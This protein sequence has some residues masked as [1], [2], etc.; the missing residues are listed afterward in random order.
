MIKY[1]NKVRKEDDLYMIKIGICDD[2]EG[3]LQDMVKIISE[4]DFEGDEI[5]VKSFSNGVELLNSLNKN[6]YD[7]VFMDVFLRKESGIDVIATLVEMNPSVLIYYMTSYP[8]HFVGKPYVER[9]G[10]IEKK[11]GS[12]DESHVIY[13]LKRGLRRII[14]TRKI[15]HT[16]KFNKEL[17]VIDLNEVSYI[18]SVDRRIVVVMTNGQEYEFYGKL[19]KV[20]EEVYEKYPHFVRP[21]QD[22]VVNMIHN[23]I[24]TPNY[25]KVGNEKIEVTK[26]YQADYN[27]KAMKHIRAGHD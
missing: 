10:F 7:I 1:L 8:D 14:Q 21:R 16:F 17:Y 5:V 22:Y 11:Q 25:I 27:K 6:T 2:D 18:K 20:Y 23:R 19:G 26:K 13:E 4:Y 15:Y 3:Y 12:F 24:Y 9:F